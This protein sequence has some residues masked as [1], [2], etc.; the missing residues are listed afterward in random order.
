MLYL[1]SHQNAQREQSLVVNVAEKKRRGR[2]EL[3]F[4]NVVFPHTEESGVGV[5][6][7]S[8]YNGWKQVS[9]NRRRQHLETPMVY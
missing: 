5:N 3:Q 7:T 4:A 8:T 9:L 2:G 6:Y 1:P